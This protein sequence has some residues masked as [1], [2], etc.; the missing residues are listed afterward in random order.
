MKR[1]LL[2]L[3]LWCAA[4][5][6]A[7]SPIYPTASGTVGVEMRANDF[8]AG[9][10]LARATQVAFPIMGGVPLGRRFFLDVTSSYAVTSLQ[11]VDGISAD[12]RGFTDTRVRAAYTFGRDAGVVSFEI[13]LPTG[14]EQV[15]SDE[16]P[17]LRSI[18]QNFLPFPVTSYGVGAGVT[19]AV[20]TARRVGAWTV[21]VAGAMR[22][23]SSY[24]PFVDLHGRYAP[25]IE[26]RVRLG[27]R[28]VIGL[29]TSLTAGFTVSTFG[30]DEFTTDQSFTYSPGNRYI[31][32]L[33]VAH[34]VGRST[35]RAFS[36]GYWRQ[37]GDSSGTAIAQAKER[38]LYGGAIWSLPLS[39]RVVL[40][41]GFEARTWRTVDGA[42]GWFGGVNGAARIRV[43]RQ[44]TVAPT[45][46]F[47]RGH[48]VVA[49]GVSSG[50]SG[51][52]G[53]FYVRVVR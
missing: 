31:G 44:L 43:N 14:A 25:G 9:V 33:G 1:L 42:S 24:A 45:V 32:E 2:W 38:V 49:D 26:G 29:N 17:L 40:D 3:S 8:G 7:Q 22:Y 16:M 47:E 23:V 28:R 51:L 52:A 20:S 27:V 12:L 11:S 6:A 36:W 18:A 53:S 5:V 4:P 19:G 37:Q 50:F 46:R 21:G 41:P 30:S 15:P 13:N 10:R 48:I 35:L 39:S 34:S